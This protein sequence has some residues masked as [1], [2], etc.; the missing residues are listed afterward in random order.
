MNNLQH[1]VGIWWNTSN[2]NPRLPSYILPSL[3]QDNVEKILLVTSLD[4]TLESLWWEAADKAYQNTSSKISILQVF[5]DEFFQNAAPVS[6]RA[7][8]WTNTYDQTCWLQLW[9]EVENRIPEPQEAAINNYISHFWCLHG[10]ILAKIYA[11]RHA[12]WFYDISQSPQTWVLE[13]IW[14]PQEQIFNIFREIISEVPPEAFQRIFWKSFVKNSVNKIITPRKSMVVQYSEAT[15]KVGKKR[16]S[17]EY[18]SDT[19][20]WDILS[21]YHWSHQK[22]SGLHHDIESIHKYVDPKTYQEFWSDITNTH[23]SF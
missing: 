22:K 11:V 12:F 1:I 21:H 15:R 16:K 20:Q 17:I 8:E 18:L 14:W 19:N 23:P 2:P 5:R 10:E 6:F 3:I 4:A 7:Q 13:S 9:S